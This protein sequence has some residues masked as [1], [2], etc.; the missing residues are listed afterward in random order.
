INSIWLHGMGAQ[1]HVVPLADAVWTED[2]FTRGLALAAGTPE[3]IP[4]RSL[5]ADALVPGRTLALLDLTSRSYAKGD[6]VSWLDAMRGLEAD[7]FAPALVALRNGHLTT[8]RLVL[9]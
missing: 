5:T 9:G 3:Q 4:P 7:W 8:L 2:L 1:Q 6:W